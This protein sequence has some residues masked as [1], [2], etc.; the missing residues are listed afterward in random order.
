[1]CLHQRQITLVVEWDCRLMVEVEGGF[2]EPSGVDGCPP[3]P[4]MWVMMSGALFLLLKKIED[5]KRNENIFWMKR[6]F[7]PQKTDNSLQFIFFGCKTMFPKCSRSTTPT[8][9]LFN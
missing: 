3:H 2:Y 9:S 1:M 7:S 5:G 6:L 8:T 4:Y